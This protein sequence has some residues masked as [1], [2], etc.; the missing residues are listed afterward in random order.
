MKLFAVY[1]GGDIKGANIELHDMRFVLADSIESSYD[2]VR[3]QWWGTPSSLHIDCWC[4]LSRAD[5]YRILLKPEPSTDTKKLYYVNVGGY[6]GKEFAELHKNIFV[7]EETESKAKVKNQ[8]IWRNGRVRKTP[9][10]HN[11]AKSS[12]LVKVCLE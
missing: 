6:D 11:N 8:G 1:I 2:E 4:E 5:G 9:T 10:I 12:P 3:R 7:V